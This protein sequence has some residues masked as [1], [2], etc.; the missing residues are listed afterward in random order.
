MLEPISIN[1]GTFRPGYA[2][3]RRIAPGHS[4]VSYEALEVQKVLSGVAKHTEKSQALFGEKAASISQLRALNSDCDEPGW[5][6]NPMAV[7]L[8]EDFVR[9][10]P[11]RIPMP[12]FAAEPDGS[13]SLDWIQSRS[14]LFSISVGSNNRLA[15]AWLD[16]TDKGHGVARFDRFSIP[17]LV[18]EGILSVSNRAAFRTT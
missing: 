14:R 12:E 3:P 15:Y 5:A 18:L 1:S 9:A 2:A 17:R 16:G 8:A 10:L 6:I 7:D 13:V 4:A 11:D